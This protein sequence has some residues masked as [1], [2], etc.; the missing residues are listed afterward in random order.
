MIKNKSI[1]FLIGAVFLNSAHSAELT[2][3]ITDSQG[4]A[5]SQAVV[6][7][8]LENKAQIPS[9]SKSIVIDQIDKEFVNRLTVIQTGTSILFPNHDKIRHHVYSFSEAKN[10]ELPLYEGTPEKPIV[11]EKAGAITLGCNI[12]DWMSAYIFVVDTPFFKL[13]NDEGIA[14]ID[15]PKDGQYRIQAWHPQLKQLMPTEFKLSGN[16]KQSIAFQMELK[17][18]FHALRIPS[19]AGINGGY[20]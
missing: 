20:R 12:H 3:K 8:T 9:K 16:Q 10:F 18:H 6:Y 17:K 11:F 5:V 14:L 7:A 13:T 2:V 19:S 1:R 4:Q 15:L